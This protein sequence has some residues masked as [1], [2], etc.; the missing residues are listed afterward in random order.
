[1]LIND[2]PSNL[3][4]DELLKRKTVKNIDQKNTKKIFL[5]KQKKY[6][7]VSL[8]FKTS[9]LQQFRH[10]E[11]HYH[12]L[13]APLI[14]TLISKG[15]QGVQNGKYGV[16]NKYYCYGL[17]HC[18]NGIHNAG[19]TSTCFPR[20]ATVLTQSNNKRDDIIFHIGFEKLKEEQYEWS[21]D[22]FNQ[23]IKFIERLDTT[24]YMN[25]REKVLVWNDVLAQHTPRRQSMLVD[26]NAVC[27][28]IPL[29]CMVRPY[30]K[31]YVKKIENNSDA[32]MV[33]P[34]SNNHFFITTEKSITG[35]MLIES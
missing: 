27:H 9:V 29:S 1:M 5:I 25:D 33:F 15:V 35:A 28:D 30:N 34:C 2:E 23:L 4:F 21:K 20:K 7:N 24:A 8:N 26:Y 11:D 31:H 32:M 10:C 3:P 6:P 14:Y 17:L 22:K 13:S 19:I 16:F 18:A 12:C